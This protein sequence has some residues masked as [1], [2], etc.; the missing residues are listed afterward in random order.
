MNIAMID[1]GLSPI[2]LE[3]VSW[4]LAR[5]EQC[6]CVVKRRESRTVFDLL[7]DEK[8][9]MAECLREFNAMGIFAMGYHGPSFI[10][11][12]PPV[13]V[14]QEFDRV[15]KLAAH[16]PL[17]S[18]ELIGAIHQVWQEIASDMEGRFDNAEAIETVLDADRIE[19]FGYKQAAVELEWLDN[20][21]GPERVQLALGRQVKLV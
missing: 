9:F 10:D 7:V 16:K 17:F 13:T 19:T 12:L 14:R 8:W 11:S 21:F 18:H 20:R 5:R 4:L 1:C 15:L 6:G 2:E 3:A